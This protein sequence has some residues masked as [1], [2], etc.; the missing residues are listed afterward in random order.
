MYGTAEIEVGGSEPA[1]FVP[2]S[3]PQ[4]INGQNHVFVRVSPTRFE[5][6]PVELGR[7]LDGQFEVLAGLRAGEEVVSHG[8][9]LLKSQL[10]K[11]TLGE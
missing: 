8:S 6:R 7:T 9:F 11:S 4:E 10:L 2:G 1:L 5:A 3:A